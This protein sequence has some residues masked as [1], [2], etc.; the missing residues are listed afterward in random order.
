MPKKNWKAPEPRDF[1]V[2][3]NYTAA[4]R[5]RVDAIAANART[6]LAVFIREVSLGTF[7]PGTHRDVTIDGVRFSQILGA[8]H[9]AGD[10]LKLLVDILEFGD[11]PRA[12]QWRELES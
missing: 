5:K 9:D 2:R 8:L 10:R 12:Q 6:P 11:D 7:V 3:V 1:P 4:E